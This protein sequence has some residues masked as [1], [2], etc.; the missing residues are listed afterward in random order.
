MIVITDSVIMIRNW[1]SVT[2]YHAASKRIVAIHS[3]RNEHL[4]CA[5]SCDQLRIKL[6]W[7]LIP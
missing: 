2:S 4:L 3:D 6:G 1:S 7:V 5:E